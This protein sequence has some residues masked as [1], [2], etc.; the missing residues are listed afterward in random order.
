MGQKGQKEFSPIENSIKDLYTHMVK[1]LYK[2]YVVFK[3][4]K[5]DVFTLYWYAIESLAE[6]CD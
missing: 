3:K 4:G 1:L 2:W 6:N 5:N